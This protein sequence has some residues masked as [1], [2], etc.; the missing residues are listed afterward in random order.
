M[1]QREHWVFATA[2]D[3][4]TRLLERAALAERRARLLTALDG[5]VLDVGAGTGANLPYLEKASRVVVAEP[6][7]AMRRRLASR[8]ARTPAP[9]ELSSDAAER[10]RYADGSFDAVVFTLVLCSVASPDQALAE[11]RR[12]LRPS[13]RLIVL[14]HV[15]GRG[16][17]A[18]WQDRLTPVWSRLNAGCH[19]GRDTFAAIE[20][21]GF[22]FEQARYSDPYPRWVPARPMLEAVARP[23]TSVGA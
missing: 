17:L 18:R 21:A 6:D 5:Q 3:P 22:V 8:L 10:L 19:L 23:G 14:E 4:A 16:S 2:Y 15:R 9:T 11:A 1:P 7:P 20:R 13:G 12:V